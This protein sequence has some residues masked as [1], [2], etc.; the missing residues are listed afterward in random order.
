MPI[1]YVPCKEFWRQKDLLISKKPIVLGLSGS[2]LIVGKCFKIL[3]SAFGFEDW[4]KALPLLTNFRGMSWTDLWKTHPIVNFIMLEHDTGRFLE[5]SSNIEHLVEKC[6]NIFKEFR[7]VTQT[8]FWK[9][10]PNMDEFS[11]NWSKLDR[12]THVPIFY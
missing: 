8:N 1:R 11:R 4:K 5:N 9:T 6:R 3:L 10:D 7:V 2:K 12:L